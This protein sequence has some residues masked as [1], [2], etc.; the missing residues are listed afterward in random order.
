MNSSLRPIS[1]LRAPLALMATFVL[2][3]TAAMLRG[4]SSAPAT[5]SST[6]LSVTGDIT[7][8]LS[9]T[10]DT[11][12]QMPRKTIHARLWLSRCGAC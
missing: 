4:Q 2:L 9:L 5:N 3:S 6:G 12:K 1:R 10:L 8:P 7:H 11:L